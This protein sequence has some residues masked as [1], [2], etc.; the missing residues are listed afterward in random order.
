M[1]E[2]SDYIEV[3]VHR[4]GIFKDKAKKLVNQGVS[5]VISGGKISESAKRILDENNV[6]HRENVEPSDLESESKETEK[7]V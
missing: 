1:S 7:E 2:E 4:Q 6:W 5:G 3:K